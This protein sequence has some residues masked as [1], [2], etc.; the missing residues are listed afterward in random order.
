MKDYPFEYLLGARKG[1][2]LLYDGDVPIANRITCPDEHVVLFAVGYESTHTLPLGLHR[3]VAPEFYAGLT[4]ADPLADA[5]ALVAA[6]QTAGAV[7]GVAH[8]EENDLSAARIIEVGLDAME[9]YNPHGNFKTALGGDSIG[10]DPQA[11]FDLLEGLLPFMAGSNSGAHPDLVYLKLL[12]AWP[13]EGFAKWRE[14]LRGRPITGLFGSDVHQNVSVDPICAQN[15]P[16]LQAACV[17]AAEAVL[18]EALA[19][20]VDGGTLTMSDGERLDSYARIFR[21]LEN[22]PLLDPN[23]TVDLA[24]I[25][26]ALANGRSYGLFSVFGEPVDFAF[27]AEGEGATYQIG[28]V[29]SL[30]LRLVV[31]APTAAAPMAATGPQWGAEDGKKAAIQAVLVRTDVDGS[32]EVAQLDAL[33]GR[34]EY[35]LAVSGAYHVEVWVRPGH[36]AGALGEEAGLAETEYLWLITNPIYAAS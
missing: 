23:V 33:G 30:P 36:L 35:D 21:W 2:E 31:Q 27:V 9:W 25:Q 17:A 11:V 1:D 20:L 13:V 24:A 3:H 4:D 29:L 15:D 34:L 8:S 16:L 19:G 7:V 10:G 6:L 5:S 32:E 18:P 12:P 26:E 14:V 22:R 28:D